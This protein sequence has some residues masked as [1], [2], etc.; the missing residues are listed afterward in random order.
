[1]AKKNI[2]MESKKIKMSKERILVIRDNSK[3][4]KK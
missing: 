1:M 4:M 3:I 2:L